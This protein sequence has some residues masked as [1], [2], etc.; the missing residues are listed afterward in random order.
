MDWRCG[1]SSRVPAL[2]EQNPEFNKS[3]SHQKKERKKEV[4]AKGKMRK[5][6]KQVKTTL[7]AVLL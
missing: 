3:Q 7:L 6:R 1:S 2:Q 5:Q 4:K